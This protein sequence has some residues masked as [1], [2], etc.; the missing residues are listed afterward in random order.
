MHSTKDIHSNIHNRKKAKIVKKVINK[1]LKERIS[2]KEATNTYFD[3]NEIL[4]PL[5]GA[6]SSKE[7]IES[8]L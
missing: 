1:H 8:Y 6:I 2:V 3:K 7:F 5:F 4:N